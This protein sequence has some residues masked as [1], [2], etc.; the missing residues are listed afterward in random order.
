LPSVPLKLISGYANDLFAAR[1]AASKAAL[2]QLIPT[3]GQ[4]I[5]SPQFAPASRSVAIL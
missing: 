5:L 3:A 4:M 2:R 1:D